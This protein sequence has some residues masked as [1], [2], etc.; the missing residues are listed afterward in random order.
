MV[1]AGAIGGFIGGQLARSGQPTAALARGATL[2]AL[3]THGWRVV[4]DEG[5]FTAPVRASDNAAEL[6]VQ[7]LVI[8]AVKAQTMP[9][10]IESIGPLIG[11]DTMVL[12]AMNGVPWWFFD[13]F[14]G[15]CE[16]R[17]LDSVD[18]A[19]R[20]AAA[21]PVHHVIGGVV[22]MNCGTLEP[23]LVR[24]YRG[25]GLIVGEPDDK[26]SDRLHTVAGLLRDGGFD[27]TTST[28]IHRDVWYKLWGNLTINPVSVLTG[29]TADR[30][31]D[32]ELVRGFC[33]SAMVEAQ[34]IGDAIGCPITESPAD[35]NKITRKLGAFRSS[36]LMD[37]ESGRGLELDALVGAVH[38]IGAIVG[39]PTPDVDALLGLTRLNAAV[40]GLGT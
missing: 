23:G 38:E 12:T 10:V 34:L 35:R 18:P 21:I 31:L 25:A 33:Q 14:G 40:R 4:S 6:G 37:A 30:I 32:D 20:I 11:P 7:D 17:H 26:D 13:G 29:A 3:R 39:V 8:V 19:G 5:E 22:H 24:H 2:A 16:G 27:V 36:M 15:P 9:S 1:G 28:A